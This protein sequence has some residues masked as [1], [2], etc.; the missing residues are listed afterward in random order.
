MPRT[1]FK[2]DPVAL[3][4]T[5]E[6]VE[7]CWVLDG[8]QIW[9]AVVAGYGGGGGPGTRGN[10]QLFLKLQVVMPQMKLNSI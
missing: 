3:S 6:L 1:Y 8:K 4:T 9:K 5:L 7:V 10:T 2:D